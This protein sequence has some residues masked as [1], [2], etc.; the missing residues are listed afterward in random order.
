MRRDLL[1]GVRSR[2]LATREL[3]RGAVHSSR[4]VPSRPPRHHA[5]APR[6]HAPA[7]RRD[8]GRLRPPSDPHPPSR[9]RPVAGARSLVPSR[10]RLRPTAASAQW[11]SGQSAI[12]IGADRGPPAKSSG[13]SGSGE[14]WL[15][16]P[17]LLI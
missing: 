12:R 3:G 9:P 13:A 1:V 2:E 17:G 11:G 8:S 6:V 16:L 14:L 10:L 15:P 4:P 7:V 5:A